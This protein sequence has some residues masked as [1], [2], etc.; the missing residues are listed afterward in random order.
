MASLPNAESPSRLTEVA[1]A[2]T[3]AGD[4]PGA[5]LW[6]RAARELGDAPRIAIVAKDATVAARVARRLEADHPACRFVAF[7]FDAADAGL[8]ARGEDRLLGVHAVLWATAPPAPLGAEE[9]DAIAALPGLGAPERRA[10]ALVD[11]ALLDRIADDPDREHAEIL[12]RLRALLPDGWSLVT[13][14]ELD[15]VCVAVEAALPELRDARRRDV[16]RFLLEDARRQADTALAAERDAIAGIAALL[17]EQDF[18]LARAAAD[19]ERIAAH[20]AAAVRRHAEALLADLRGFLVA[21]ENDLRDQITAVDDLDTVRRTLPHWLGHV[22]GARLR[23]GLADWRARVLADLAEVG[24]GEADARRA[25]LLLPALHPPP[26]G[27]DGG[28]RHRLAVTAAVGGGAVMAAVGLWL[29]GALVATSGLLWSAASRRARDGDARERLIDAA[30]QAVRRLGEDATRT[31]GDQLAQIEAD[32]GG[33][34]AERAAATGATQDA[35]RARLTERRAYHQA[36][37][38]ALAAQVE[39]LGAHLEALAG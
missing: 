21:L 18:E 7:A 38:D 23:D 33:L 32:L 11:R 25:E 3:E 20:L 24:I 26:V 6:M 13:E 22:V 30:R 16:A 28:W 27:G 29:P 35:L 36:R 1:R 31:F 17:S 37:H 19:G 8:T 4:A 5:A 15:G 34:A 2:L 39:R 9:R 12:D 14:A 10:I